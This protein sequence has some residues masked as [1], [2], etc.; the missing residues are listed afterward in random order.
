MLINLFAREILLNSIGVH[1]FFYKLIQMK[2]SLLSSS[3][4][5]AELNETIKQLKTD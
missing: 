1:I 3:F 5:M 2:H 4:N